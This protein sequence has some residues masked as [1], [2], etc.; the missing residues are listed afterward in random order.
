MDAWA[1]ALSTVEKLLEG[2]S[3]SINDGA[4]ILAL[5]SWHVF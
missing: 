1:T 5:T 3:Q 4:V 2:V